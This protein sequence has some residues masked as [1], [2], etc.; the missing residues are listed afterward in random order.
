MQQGVHS[1]A[2]PVDKLEVARFTQPRLELGAQLAP[3]ALHPV[4]GDRS[5]RR[6]AIDE[7]DAVE[8]SLVQCVLIMLVW[9]EPEVE[10]AI[11][12]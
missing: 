2:G 9:D 3:Y 1:G 7:S 6:R 4:D 8:A 5:G 12:H 10:P 11:A